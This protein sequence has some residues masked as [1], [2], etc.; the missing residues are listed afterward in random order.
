MDF[1]PTN[2][3][4]A[5]VVAQLSD[6]SVPDSGYLAQTDTAKYFSTHGFHYFFF[7][8]LKF[9]TIPSPTPQKKQ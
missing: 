8:I 2:C 9:R 5:L 1:L 4:L 6:V 3:A 7:S